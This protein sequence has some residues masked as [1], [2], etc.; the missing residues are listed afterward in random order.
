MNALVCFILFC[1][2]ASPP[3]NVRAV[4]DGLTSIRMTWT[5]PS[6]LGNTTGYE[7]SYIRRGRIYSVYVYDSNANSHILTRLT[8]GEFYTINMVGIASLDILPSSPVTAGV[9][10][11]GM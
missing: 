1:S 10:F 11:L 4:Q 3:S 2:G 6:P 9:V 8:N 5:P 7:I